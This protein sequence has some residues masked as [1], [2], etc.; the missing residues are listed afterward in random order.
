MRDLQLKRFGEIYKEDLCF[1]FHSHT[2]WT[3]GT[4]SIED[5]IN[6]AY[7]IGLDRFALTEHVR[8]DSNWYID[9]YKEA[10]RLS[11]DSMEIIVG[12]ES[13]LQNLQGDID[14]NRDIL[15]IAEIIIGSVHS[16]PVEDDAFL[17][18]D[19]MKVLPM[20]EIRTMEFE[21]AM[22]LLDNDQ[23]DIIGHP[24]GL[25]LSIVDEFPHYEFETI[26]KKAKDVGIAIEVNTKYLKGHMSKAVH[27]LEQINPFVSFG[28]DAHHTSEIMRDYDI[29][30]DLI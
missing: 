6:I 3:D 24:M 27:I 9:F 19:S 7:S 14:I 13:R 12:V 16:F 11:K 1:D 18:F 21:R 15:D 20:K 22:I 30:R 8:A 2:L 25:Y 5:M 23:I 10:K 17:S 26:C 29:L 4:S 28:S